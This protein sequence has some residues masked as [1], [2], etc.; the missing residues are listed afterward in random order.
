MPASVQSVSTKELDRD[1]WIPIRWTWAKGRTRCLSTIKA[2]WNCTG[3]KTE[4]FTRL[5]LTPLGKSFCPFKKGCNWHAFRRN[6]KPWKWRIKVNHFGIKTGGKVQ[7][8]L[9]LQHEQGWCSVLSRLTS[10][11]KNPLPLIPSRKA[12][13]TLL[14]FFLESRSA[15][16]PDFV[17]LFSSVF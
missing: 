3:G 12:S 2:S 4:E 16:W 9:L 7:K 15:L 8:F 5:L 6:E 11:P 1:C 14:I 17:S 13:R 10:F